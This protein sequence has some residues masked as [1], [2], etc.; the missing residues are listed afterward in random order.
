M[1]RGVTPLALAYRECANHREAR[2]VGMSLPDTK[3]LP[4]EHPGFCSPLLKCLLAMGL[5]CAYFEE[6][7]LPLTGRRG[8][9]A[10]G[11][12]EYRRIAA[13]MLSPNRSGRLQIADAIDRIRD[14]EL[15]RGLG[16]H[17]FIVKAGQVGADLEPQAPAR[18]C[19]CGA[20]LGQRQRACAKCRRAADRIA[21]RQRRRN[22]SGVGAEVS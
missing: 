1:K 8:E 13:R 20:P 19:Q 17:P 21:R 11:G 4:P 7:V 6:A 18:R 22:L 12:E 2:C 15:P 10:P 16:T 9:W 5:C 14:A 3:M